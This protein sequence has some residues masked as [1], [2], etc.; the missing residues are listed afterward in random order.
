MFTSVYLA[1][2]GLFVLAVVK[3]SIVRFLPD[4]HLDNKSDQIDALS[5]SS[6]PF[7]IRSWPYTLE[8]DI[9]RTRIPLVPRS[10]SHLR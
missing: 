8:V 3:V 1:V 6:Q 10:E 5:P 4:L 2:L 9:R 7:A